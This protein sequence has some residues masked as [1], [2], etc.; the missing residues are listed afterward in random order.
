MAKKYMDLLIPRGGK[1]EVKTS[2]H[3]FPGQECQQFSRPIIA[4]LGAT[5]T[6]DQPTN[7]IVEEQVQVLEGAA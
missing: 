7:E 3:G 4:A 2:T 6:S 1:G 5:Q